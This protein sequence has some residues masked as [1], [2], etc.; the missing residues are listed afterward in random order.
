MAALFAGG[1]FLCG[2]TVVAPTKVLTAGH[3]ALNWKRSRLSV[4][5]GR[6]A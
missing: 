1:Q 3:C 2:G 4:V 6:R 5:I